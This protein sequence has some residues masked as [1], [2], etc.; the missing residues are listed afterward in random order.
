MLRLVLGTLLHQPGR[1][2]LSVLALG[3]AIAVMLLFGGFRSGL[4]SQLRDFPEQLQADLVVSQAG[5]SNLAAARSSLPQKTRKALLAVPGVASA[6]ALTVLPLIFRRHGIATPVQVIAYVDLGA[7]AEL[8]SGRHIEVAREI[9]I[10]RSL[11]ADHDLSP[12]DRVDV[13]GWS[14]EVVG[15]SRGT[16]AMFTPAVFARF[17]D[18]VDLFLSGDLS[19]ELQAD[20]P[21][22]SHMLVQV[23]PGAELA[24]ARAGI[25]RE[26]AWVDVHTPAEL[27]AAD[28][29][30]GRR[31]LGP[32]LGLL[33]GLSYVIGALV[34]GLTLYGSV[35]ARI[36]D[37]AVLAALGAGRR[38]LVSLVLLEALAVSAFAFL[39]G[40]IAASSGAVLIEFSQPD[41][42]VSPLAGWAVPRT[43]AVVF[44]L[45]LLGASAPLR[46]VL[47]VDPA[48][49]FRGG[50]C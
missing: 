12:G 3:A 38:R 5:V 15:V 8:D 19:E 7:P 42:L 36:R 46:R 14:F 24:A 41:Y 26:L 48:L 29:L 50:P 16:A 21:L 39:L 11:A 49:V 37:F 18:L 9:V 32:V 43:A 13:L 30:M 47:A 27:G 35:L 6:H 44:V 17:S 22:L 4:Y 45:A 1:T 23:E 33:V 40:L 20:A 2:V 25:E 31:L 34:V 28:E 10:D